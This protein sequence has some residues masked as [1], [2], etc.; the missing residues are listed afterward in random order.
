M[1]SRLK[2]MF[3]CATALLLAPL[4]PA[5]ARSFAVIHAFQGGN[6]DGSA[7]VS[8]LISDRA[9][10][11]Y[12]ATL[13]GGPGNGGHGY[14]TV[15]KLAPDGTVT[16]LYAFQAGSDGELPYAGVIR[17]KKGNLYGTTEAGGGTV[18][19]G[20]GCGTVFRIAPDGTEALL[21]SFQGL[22]DAF[23]PTSGL[24]ADNA[25]NFY[26]TA[27]GGTDNCGTVFKIAP[28]GTETI[29]HSFTCGSDGADP[30]GSVI[31]DSG[32]SLYGMTTTGGNTQLCGRAGCGVVYKLAPDGSETVLHTFTGGK[33]GG[34]PDGNLIADAAG[35][36]Y[37]MTT[38]GGRHGLGVAF[39]LAPDGT[40]TVLH[41]F[42][43]G[44]DGQEP[45]AGLVLDNA[46]NLYG[47]TPFGGLSCGFF[48]CGTVFR[49][50]SDG[51]EKVL[52]R[53]TGG[54]DG[55]GPGWADT[56]LVKRHTLVGTASGCGADGNGTIFELKK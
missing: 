6:D 40:E 27:H 39:R 56:L 19:D 38:I 28:D 16:V 49:I 21:H 5:S 41:S 18:C 10:N 55:C 22:P 26:G 32:G 15:Y 8:G 45:E 37:G 11:L 12:G 24:A 52:Y 30:F 1:Q 53:F 9:G 43:H 14:G 33:D 54:S 44:L 50:A 42:G 34:E 46:G 35:N 13:S 51:T 29:L 23:G 48:T 20:Y 31:V 25:G 7:S 2:V 17:D 36:L 3:V 4:S 47:T